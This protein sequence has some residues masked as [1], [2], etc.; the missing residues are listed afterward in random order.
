MLNHKGTQE[1]RTERLLLRRVRPEDYKDMYR[2]MHK[3][4]VAR[5]M[6]WEVHKDIETTKALCKMW[7][8][9]YRDNTRYNWAIELDGVA[10][11]NIDVIKITDSTAYMGW[12]LDSIFWNKG[13]M[14][15]AAAAVR[16]YLFYKIG[17]DAME[18]CHIEAN[19][20]SGRVMQKIGMKQIP[21]EESIYFK[22]EGTCKLNGMPIICY[23]LTKEEWQCKNT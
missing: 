18:A 2:Y 1:I 12:Q 10:V 19:I 5:Y 11:G 23:R 14:T 3:E 17:I 22:S 20:G 21:T 9:E 7:S 4:E 13:L 6:T 15:E 8:E 16:D